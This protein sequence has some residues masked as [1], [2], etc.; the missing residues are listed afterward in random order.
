MLLGGRAVLDPFLNAHMRSRLHHI[1]AESE[2]LL[3]IDALLENPAALVAYAAE[4]VVFSPAYGPAGGYPGLR[5]PAPLDY[6]LAVVR[7]LDPLLR[8]AFDLGAARLARAECNFSLVTLAPDALV[9]AQRVPHVDTTYP[10]QFAFLHYLCAPEHG[11]TAFYRHR[12]TG[13][14]TLTPERDTAYAAARAGEADEGSGYILGDTAYFQRT[15]S[16]DA[17]F[18]RLIVYRSRMLHSGQVGSSRLSP[19]PRRGRLTANMF[20]NYHQR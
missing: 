15:G 3:E 1:G 14:E 4:E 10:L 18:N 8:E 17:A 9:P 20:V 11:G 19:D 12:A 7:A 2:P 16:V 5:A 13:F 6:V